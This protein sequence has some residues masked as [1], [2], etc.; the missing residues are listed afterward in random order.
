[1]KFSSVCMAMAA[2]GLAT[3]VAPA[4]PA[5]TIV[6]PILAGPFSAANPL[7]T[8]QSIKLVTGNTYDFT[9]TL[10]GAASVLT[11][12]QASIPGPTSEPIQY[13][14]F[15]GLPGAGV[16]VDMS[17]KSIAPSLTDMLAKGDYYLQVDYIAQ[18]NELLSGGLAIAVPEPAA[19]GMMLLGL[20][21]LGGVLRAN[22]RKPSLAAA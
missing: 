7:G 22:R 14:I 9:F 6:N 20:A 17:T 1:M 2:M 19:W 11:Q 10:S 8:I 16:L 3:A 4:A 12:M 21:G 5:M 15:K 13:T 18:N